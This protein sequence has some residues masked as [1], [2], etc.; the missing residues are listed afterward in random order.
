MGTIS[1]MYL[2]YRTKDPTSYLKLANEAKLS[3]GHIPIRHSRFLPNFIE[4]SDVGIRRITHNL[5]KKK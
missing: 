3:R 1:I 2:V 4:K 5:R